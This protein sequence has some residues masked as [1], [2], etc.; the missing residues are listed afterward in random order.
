M[1]A[2]LW[3]TGLVLESALTL[4]ALALL[5][6]LGTWQLVRKGEKEALI[7][8][9]QARVHAPVVPLAEAQ[10]L[11]A[12]GADVSY[13]H[14]VARGQF[15]N[16]KERYLYA[17]T[18]V[19]PGWHVY[20]PLALAPGRFVWINR[21][22]IPDAAKAPESRAA[23]ELMGEVMVAGLVRSPPPKKGLF[24]PDNDVAGNVWYWP[25]LAAMSASAVPGAQFLPFAIEADATPAPPG[26]LPRGG[27]TRLSLPNRHLEY[28]L[29]W[30][31]LA[32]ALIAVYF[33]FARSHRR[34]AR[35]EGR[36]PEPGA[37]S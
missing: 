37:R 5:C 19:G 7:A 18:P 30:Y 31:G 14:V 13:L 34:R 17:P 16:E 25:D 3:P 26:G 36:G 32:L 2:R 27:V 33:P 23:G 6:G 8:T 15:L 11:S 9:L 12:G 1:L 21:G 20:T 29:T 22:F 4:T 24:V 35:G 28:A 10:A